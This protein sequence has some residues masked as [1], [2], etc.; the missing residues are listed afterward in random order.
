MNSILA[1]IG[2]LIQFLALIRILLEYFRL[3]RT[4]GERLPRRVLDQYV[5]GALITAVLCFL[6]VGLYFF[7]FYVA[8]A[9]ISGLTVVVLLIYKFRFMLPANGAKSVG[10]T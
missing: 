1:K 5:T 8:A 3:Q 2:I 9:V 4:R 7:G 6:S 10:S